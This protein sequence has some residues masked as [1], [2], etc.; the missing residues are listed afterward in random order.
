VIGPTSAEKIRRLE[1]Q[2]KL[3]CA[4][5]DLRPSDFDEL[6]PQEVFD[7]AR[8][9]QRVQAV[10]VLRARG[11]SLVAGSRVVDAISRHPV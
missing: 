2:V 9:G 1:L 6:I 8:D 5:M 10:R 4:A 11:F 3:L 7:L